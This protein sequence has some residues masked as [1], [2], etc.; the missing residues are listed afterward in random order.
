MA[1]PTFNHWPLLNS[2]LSLAVQRHAFIAY[3]MAGN[4]AGAIAIYYTFGSLIGS[5]LA[6]RVAQKNL[7]RTVEIHFHSITIA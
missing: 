2:K 3:F 5:Q 7:H 4:I 1:P 6:L